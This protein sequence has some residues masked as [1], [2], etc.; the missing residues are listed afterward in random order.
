MDSSGGFRRFAFALA[1]SFCLLGVPVITHAQNATTT[2]QGYIAHATVLKIVSDTPTDDSTTTPKSYTEIVSARITDGKDR[3]KLVEFSSYYTDGDG[4]K[5]SAGQNI[6]VTRFLDQD[7]SNSLISVYSYSSVDHDRMPIVIIFTILFLGCIVWIGGKQGIRGLVSL[8]GG[9]CLVVFVLLPG[10]IHGYSPVLLSILI[11]SFVSSIGAYITHGFSRM[12]TSAIIGMVLTIIVAALLAQFAVH[13][14]YLSGITDENSYNLLTSPEPGSPP[15]NFQ[16]LLL[17]SIIIGLLGV[18]YDAAIGQ[19]V[20]VEELA[21]AGPNLPRK[22]IYER[23]FRIGREHIGAL[24]NTLVLA[25]VGASL[26][27]MISVYESTTYYTGYATEPLVNM[28]FIATEIIRTTVGA[29]GLMLTIPITTFIAV[30]MLVGTH[31]D[32]SEETIARE[33][34][35][36]ES[37]GHRHSTSNGDE[38]DDVQF[39]PYG[40]FLPSWKAYK[41]RL[42]L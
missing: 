18:L 15:I 17:G 14:G 29:V 40:L 10:V 7:Q 42:G 41:K 8:V 24:V 33:R 37:V 12:T 38:N 32:A 36:T 28:E 22:L 19:S 21:H 23:A 2:D 11:A 30:L 3:G 13:F 16:G 31:S 6:Y 26:P 25:Y 35:T 20:A 39:Q 27:I 1:T 5:I 4:Q 34:T 9:I